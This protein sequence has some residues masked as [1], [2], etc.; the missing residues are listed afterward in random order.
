[1]IRGNNIS[2]GRGFDGEFAFVGQEKAKELQSSI[3]VADDLV[4]PHRGAIGTV[5]IVRHSATDKWILSTSL[6]KLTCDPTIACPD[7]IFYF[8]RSDLGRS[9]LLRYA[10]TVGTPGIGQ[11]LTSLRSISVLLP[12]IA[13]QRAIAEVLGAL[14]DKIE[15]N[16]RVIGLSSDL[17]AATWRERFGDS[18]AE[19]WP[20]APIGEVASVVGG[21]T[22]KTGVPEYWDGDIH[23]ATPK[24]LSRLVS[25]PLL[26][27]ERHI[28]DLGLA[29][30]SSSLLPIGTVLLSS[31]APVGYVAIAEVP[32]AV[33]QGFIAL[34]P[35]NLL[36]SVYLWQW[37]VA[38]MDDIKARANGTT[39]LEVSKASFRPIPL[40]VPP[41]DRVATWAELAEALYRQ[42]VQQERE[43][44]LIQELRDTLLPKLL[45]GELRVQDAA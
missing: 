37:L 9:A 2:S 40:A 30:I 43:V 45:S 29:K 19:D 23:W 35:G 8:F 33:N 38:H 41:A 42:I 24:D 14:D 27:T 6:M 28:S 39:F 34:V 32:V 3:V 21:T 5:G 26:D 4:F 13:E 44:Q 31:R 17:I 22:P 12:P 10:S 25:V 18:E 20:T 16:R 15:S 1:M 36:P 11:P 7:F